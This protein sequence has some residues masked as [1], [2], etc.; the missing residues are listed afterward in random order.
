M[1]W[2]ESGAVRPPPVF[3]IRT[4]AVMKM[5]LA[6]MH[7]PSFEAVRQII[8]LTHLQAARSVLLFLIWMRLSAESFLRRAVLGDTQTLLRQDG[9]GV[10]LSEGHGHTSRQR[11]WRG[12]RGKDASLNI[13]IVTSFVNYVVN[14]VPSVISTGTDDEAISV[15]E[16]DISQVS[17]MAQKAFVFGL[18][19]IKYTSSKCH[20]YYSHQIYLSSLVKYML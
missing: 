17:R 18:K 12:H 13:Y 20:F 10:I 1:T 16:A 9:P 7:A 4:D 15:C 19:Q 5:S 3:T 11:G 8:T 14:F 6:H 2:W